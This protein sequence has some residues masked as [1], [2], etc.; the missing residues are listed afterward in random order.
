MGACRTRNRQ[1]GAQ[2]AGRHI[3]RKKQS[4]VLRRPALAIQPST[5][6]RLGAPHGGTDRVYTQ[7]VV[8]VKKKAFVSSGDIGLFVAFSR[9]KQTTVRDCGCYCCSSHGK[10]APGRQAGSRGSHVLG[11]RRIVGEGGGPYQQS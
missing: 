8:T 7:P 9:R 11:I 1:G 10:E 2:P 6:L 4:E 5:C 3:P